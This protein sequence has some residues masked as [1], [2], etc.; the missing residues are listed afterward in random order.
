MK[1]GCKMKMK[2]QKLGILRDI[3]FLLVLI[4]LFSCKS[5][6]DPQTIQNYSIS[7]DGY[8]NVSIQSVKLGKPVIINNVQTFKIPLTAMKY[9]KETQTGLITKISCTDTISVLIAIG[10][11]VLKLEDGYAFVNVREQSRKNN[12]ILQKGDLII[13]NILLTLE[14]LNDLYHEEL[15]KMFR[16][17]VEDHVTK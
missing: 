5:S 2:N 17:G 10:V 7:T 14:K 8:V 9:N 15:K 16:L 12:D 6:K 1:W 4:S 11:H 13:N 3:F